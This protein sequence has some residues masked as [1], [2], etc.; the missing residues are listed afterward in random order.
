MRTTLILLTTLALS[1][2]GAIAEEPPAGIPL[3]PK[4]CCDAD[5]AAAVAEPGI[6]MTCIGGQDAALCKRVCDYVKTSVSCPVRMVPAPEGIAVLPRAEQ[7]AKVAA[8]KGEKDIAVLAVCNLPDEAAFTAELFKDKQVGMV[9]I[10][11]VEKIAKEGVT[12][13]EQNARM[14]ERACVREA[15]LLIGLEDCPWPRCAMHVAP[16]DSPHN[17][18]GRN[19]CPPCQ[20]KAMKLIN[21]KGIVPLMERPM[22][23]PAAAD[24]PV[25][26]KP[27]GDKPAAEHPVEHPTEHP[28]PA[29]E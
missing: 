6:V 2:L 14:I 27:T 8:L 24:K 20:G 28:E 11:T 13:E 26:E 22:T 23:P 15:G 10:A 29:E 7:A 12:P 25:A 19:L 16:K 3:P 18:R 17:I 4:A 21:A 9:N 1:T 5:P